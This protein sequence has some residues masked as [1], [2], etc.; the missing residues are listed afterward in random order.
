MRKGQWVWLLLWLIFI[1]GSY[2]YFIRKHIL[3]GSI[4]ETFFR[5]FL[6]FIFLLIN[7]A[8]G[9]KV[10]RWLKFETDSFLESSLFSLA[11]GLAIFTYLL[12]GF[13]LMGLFNK[14]VINFLVVGMFF[15]TYNEIG[16]FIQ[17]TK[18]K[19]KN[20]VNLKLPLIETILF[21]I[22]FVQIVFNL[23][24]AS[25]LP[26]NWDALAVH[27][28][29]PKEWIRLS[30]LTSVPYL[31]FG[32]GNSPYNIGILY[33]MSLLVK[34]VILAKLISF[35]FG[36]LTAMGIYSLGKRYFSRRIGLFSAAI[37]YTTPIVSYVSTTAGVDLGFTFY[38]FLAAYAL[39]NWI[40]SRRRNWLII[41]AVMGGLCLG[42][43]W[44]GFLCVA[45]LSLGILVD[46]F[47]FK[48]E[49][50]TLVIKNFLLFTL[51]GG[52]IGSF[53]YLRAFII[54]GSSIFTLLYDLLKGSAQR[55]AFA[56]N[57]T[58]EIIG[59]GLNLAKAYLFLPWNITMHPGIFRGLGAIGLLFLAFLP[60]VVFPRFRRDKVIKFILYYSLIYLVFWSW[61]IPYK[62]GLIP[63]ISLLSIIVACVV[64]EMSNVNK[65]IKS[66]IFTL[67]ILGLIFQTFYLTPEGLGKVYQR[68]QVFAGLES[69][70]DY[71]IRNER[72]YSVFKYV[73]EKLPPNA[74]I[75]VMNEPRTFYCDRP[76]ITT[77]P[78]IDY[79]LLKDNR[80]L[81]AKFK[82]AEL[83]H[84]VV[85][86]YLR[87]AHGIRGSTFLLEKLKKEDLLVIYD[88]DPFVVFEIRYR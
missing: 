60:F 38:A 68:M 71:I 28:A 69:Q 2:L 37:F 74:K 48:K 63:V 36:I 79:S 14:W 11:I 59:P 70:E 24:G 22:L 19:L 49:K 85:N 53:W 75:F 66:F 42:S 40:T 1:Y 15:L 73:N 27:L 86:E 88:E 58:K 32:G 78:S 29:R 5:I 21:V 43:K 50:F 54:S 45:I 7:I 67:F 30:R 8:L 72:T 55:G 77:M 52:A 18:T 6:L 87:D 39:I 44:T 82:K 47:L 76:Y 51:L 4:G 20:L 41:S 25:V 13:G 84:F 61:S 31:R 56:M 81:L 34:D 57:V 9:Q 35:V 23:F 64:N 83:T 65:F 17:Q 10:F 12:I 3:W 16:D 80:E 46:S 33:G 26:S 62:R